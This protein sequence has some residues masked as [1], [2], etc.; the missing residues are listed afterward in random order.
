L[1][2]DDELE[3]LKAAR[4]PDNLTTTISNVVLSEAEP[5]AAISI[6]RATIIA[7]QEVLHT[8]GIVLSDLGELAQGISQ[9][10]FEEATKEMSA[11]EISSLGQRGH[12]VSFAVDSADELNEEDVFADVVLSR[13]APIAQSTPETPL[14]RTHNR[15]D[16]T[17]GG[18]NAFVEIMAEAA[19]A[20]EVVA[21]RVVPLANHS[22]VT[23]PVAA[24]VAAPIAAPIAAPVVA[25]VAAPIAAPVVAPVVAPV[26]GGGVVHV[27][28]HPA[29]VARVEL[30][31]DKALVTAPVEADPVAAARIL[32]SIA[33]DD[34][35]E[36]EVS[37][38]ERAN[39]APSPVKFANDLKLSRFNDSAIDLS[40]GYEESYLG[41]DNHTSII[42]SQNDDGVDDTY[43]SIRDQLRD[44]SP[45]DFVTRITEN[46]YTGTLSELPFKD[47]AR[48]ERPQFTDPDQ[49]NKDFV[50]LDT[51]KAKGH[52]P[53][54]AFLAALR[55]Q[56][57]LS[58][59]INYVPDIQA[60]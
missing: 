47:P 22:T 20:H 2:L 28:H 31:A 14:V 50:P 36:E 51:T 54:N 40:A 60:Q 17:I 55:R 3:L 48:Q 4:L 24:P 49:V 58:Y 13:E 42:D 38:Y 57:G 5:K 35:Y 27:I 25:P 44:M 16:V 21:S 8:D 12:A 19:P 7:A 18:R 52:D 45:E 41:K 34:G 32:T 1:S 26:A 37:E 29:L 56:L 46:P 59:N 11:V 9:I 43:S 39:S 33:N 23:A 6:I 30:L 15:S 53:L 10:I